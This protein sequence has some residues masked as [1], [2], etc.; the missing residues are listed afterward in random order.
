MRKLR[1]EEKSLKLKCSQSAAKLLENEKRISEG[2]GDEIQLQQPP[3]RGKRLKGKKKRRKR[4]K[5]EEGSSNDDQ[6]SD[7]PTAPSLQQQQ[8]VVHIMATPVKRSNLSSS[9]RPSS[10]GPT[11]RSRGA[12]PSST[13]SRSSLHS[14]SSSSLFPELEA[15]PSST[16]LID[17]LDLVLS[18]SPRYPA[19]ASGSRSANRREAF[20]MTPP[21]SLHPS[22]R[23]NERREDDASDASSDLFFLKSHPANASSGTPGWPYS[24]VQRSR[25]HQESDSQ[26]DDSTMISNLTDR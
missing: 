16:S 6:R 13:S 18:P 3:N 7:D 2:S 25:S 5:D 9:T 15:T 8:H 22:Q 1:V 14:A 26:Q 17:V 21:H 4:V 19:A 24:E 23:S 12:V 11:R 20:Q 10:A